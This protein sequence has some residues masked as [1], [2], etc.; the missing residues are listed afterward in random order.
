MFGTIYLPL[1]L[2]SNRFVL[3][4]L[5]KLFY[6]TLTYLHINVN[7]APIRAMRLGAVKTVPNYFTCLCMCHAIFCHL[8]ELVFIKLN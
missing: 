7:E 8:L 6:R 4:M 2:I 1:M 5:L 3:L